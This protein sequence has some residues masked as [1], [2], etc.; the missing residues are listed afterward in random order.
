MGSVGMA[1]AGDT[2]GKIGAVMVGCRGYLGSKNKPIPV[3][4]DRG[5]FFQ[6]ISGGLII[7]NRP[8]G[9]KIS[10]DT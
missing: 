9:F 8:V 4:V 10:G 2:K 3:Y 5:M 6:T 7:L 1:T